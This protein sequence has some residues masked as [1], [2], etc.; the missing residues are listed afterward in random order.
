MAA[1]GKT[2]IANNPIS[3]ILMAFFVIALILIL[4]IEMPNWVINFSISLNIALGIVLLMFSLFVQKPLELASFP[5]IIL[6]G[7]MFRLVLSIA[8][9]RLILAKG[10][11]GEVI[12]AFGTF[13]TGGN[14][15]V[16]GVIFLI[17][18]VVQFMVITKGAERIA[19]V[20]ARFALDAMPGKQMTIDADFNQ[21][22]I[23]PEEAVKRRED[24]QRESSLFGSMDGAMKF[25]KGD[26]IAGIIIAVI[27]IIGGLIIG[28]VMN[29]MPL[30]DAVS[31]YT[32]LT[33]GDGLSS[34]LPSLLMAISSGIVMTRS[35]GASTSLAKDVTLQILSKPQA[36]FLSCGFL[37]FIAITSGITGLPWWPFVM[38]SI[39]LL[40]AG[41]SVLVNADVQ[42]QLGQLD[43]VRKNMQDLVNPNK[44]YE[45]LGVD[46]L[47]LQVGSGLLIIAD[48]DQD[49]QLLAK[50][51]ALRQR[52][53]DELGYIIPN[54]RIMDSSAIKDNEYLIA[55]RGNTVATGVVYPSKFMVIADQWEALGKKVPDNVIVSVDPTYQSQAY[56]IDPQYIDR[57]S[58]IVAVD[59]VDVIVTHLQDCVRKYV[60]EV[61]TKTDVL[62]LME[63]VKSQDPTL[64]NDLVPTII[65]TSDLRKIFVNL[66]RE[67]VS[68][69][70]I[71]FIFERL[72][73]YARFSKEPDI[74]SER[75][76]AALGRQICLQNCNKDK[77]LY[78]LTLS[79]E[80]EKTLDDSC[81]RTE[82]GTMFLLNP[83]QVQELIETTANT[84]MKA[85][86]AVG[87]QPVILCSPRI[88]L[89][90]YQMLER[91]IPT[92]VVI[93]YSE[94]ITDI[95]VEAIDTIGEGY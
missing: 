56:W 25:V 43:A 61:M 36:L 14:M 46:V 41:I 84:L 85:H 82:L 9:T 74:L 4:L 86:Q 5:S 45:R 70:D 64:V 22:L 1:Q 27:N 6:I 58:K 83:M 3:E 44:M 30:A 65:S 20:S 54:I 81:Q 42:Q 88:R 78:A 8:S 77:V 13:V 50:I 90:L 26:T 12:H 35:T 79:S 62:K 37:M 40:F 68:I 67:K 18:T 16:G 24:L 71:I 73:D 53:T 11:A 21:G 28:V 31:K 15:V 48:P 34:Q 52:V 29:Q 91:H 17:I 92:I 63:L 76:R 32:V 69:K 2:T 10:D 66:I 19:E 93:S 75:L 89:P 51:A 7:T 49:G 47:S 95:R 72:C 59:A 33:I 80:W 94:L 87:V 57:N 60:D 38:F 55:I 39:I 23:S